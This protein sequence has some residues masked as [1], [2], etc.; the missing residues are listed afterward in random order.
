[1]KHKI[2]LFHYLSLCASLFLVACSTSNPPGPDPNQNGTPTVVGTPIGAPATATIDASGG[3]LTSPDGRLEIIIPA[4]ALDAATLIS[5]QPVTNEAPLGAG[6]GFSLTPHGQQ[7]KLPV[8]LRFHYTESDSAGSDIEALAIA[9][10]KENGIWYSFN[11]INRDSLAGTMSVS[12][13]HFSLFVMYQSLR[14]I[15]YHDSVKVGATAL[16]AVVF[17]EHA[18][19]DNDP[20]DDAYPLGSYSFYSVPEQISWSIN[21]SAQV[22]PNNGTIVPTPSVSSATYTAPPTV[23]N[24][25]SNPAAVTATVDVPGPAKFYLTSMIKVLGEP[26]ISGK[27]SLSVT[28][29]G[30]K[31]RLLGEMVETKTETGSGDFVYNLSGATIEDAGHGARSASW[32]DAGFAGTSNWVSVYEKTYAYLCEPAIANRQVTDKE[33]TTQTFSSGIAGLQ[34][35]GAQLS[36]AA[37]SSYTISLGPSTSLTAATVV[38]LKEYSGYCFDPPSETSTYQFAIPFAQYFIPYVGGG[39]EKLTGKISSTE[40]NAVKG[41]Y[42]GTD[43]YTLFS[44]NTDPVISLPV[45]YTLTVD[46]T[47]T[48]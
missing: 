27:I 31:T 29:N 30:S 21:G 8:S 38:S 22:N 36:I 14:V 24:M 18:D 6:V 33:T 43:L 39:A 32:N 11:S 12:T 47:L 16:L 44:S 42:H 20:N 5:V 9:T 10:Q 3:S 19:V 46:L 28:L 37:D 26:T 1:M 23:K 25:T 34:I 2:V 40:P 17:V 35:T 4:N 48:Q 13:M 41:V 7:F 15:P 45:E